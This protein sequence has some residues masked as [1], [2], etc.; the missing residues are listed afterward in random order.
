MPRVLR[1]GKG[2]QRQPRTSTVLGGVEGMKLPGKPTPLGSQT[3]WALQTQ[4]CRCMDSEVPF[5]ASQ[6]GCYLKVYNQ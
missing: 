2:P 5:H 6:N 3:L 4:T 1:A